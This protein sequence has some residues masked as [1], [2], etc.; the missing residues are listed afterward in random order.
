[1]ANQRTIIHGVPK[2]DLSYETA[3]LEAEGWI[4]DK[5]FSDVVGKAVN[6]RFSDGVNLSGTIIG[7]LPSNFNEGREI[8]LW[9]DN[10]ATVRPICVNHI[11][12][13]DTVITDQGMRD[14]LNDERGILAT[15]SQPLLKCVYGFLETEAL[16][17][18]FNGCRIG[19][20][21][22]A[23][24]AATQ[25]CCPVSKIFARLKQSDTGPHNSAVFEFL[26]T[27]WDEDISYCRMD[28]TVLTSLINS[29]NLPITRKSNL[30]LGLNGQ[31]IMCL[32][33][34]NVIIASFKD[35]SDM[36]DQLHIP[37]HIVSKISHEIAKG[38]DYSYFGIKFSLKCIPELQS[39]LLPTV[40]LKAIVTRNVSPLIYTTIKIKDIRT[41]NHVAL[42]LDVGAVSCLSL[43]GVKLLTFPNMFYAQ[44]VVPGLNLSLM[45]ACCY[46]FLAHHKGFKWS[47]CDEKEKIPDFRLA[48]LFQN[49]CLYSYFATGLSLVDTM[50]EGVEDVPES[51]IHQL[52]EDFRKLSDAPNY[53]QVSN[54]LQNE[55]WLV[56]QENEFMGLRVRRYFRSYG[57]SDATVVA[58]L[59]PDSNDG[60]PLWHLIH[61]DA[62]E[63]DVEYLQLMRS[64]Y[65]S[66]NVSPIFGSLSWRSSASYEINLSL[67]LPSAFETHSSLDI[68]SEDFLLFCE[69]LSA[70]IPVRFASSFPV[71]LKC[72]LLLAYLFPVCYIALLVVKFHRNVLLSLV[73]YPVENLHLYCGCIVFIGNLS[74]PKQC[75]G[76]CSSIADLADFGVFG[77]YW[78]LH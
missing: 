17:L 47:K 3:S 50:I 49:R 1:L 10:F 19:V 12:I 33:N 28:N 68:T 8:Y 61:D 38:I 14:S 62:D 24:D 65:N 18:S 5:E 77:R 58:Y 45:L 57:F 4:F 34:N 54:R 13:Q 6:L 67:H 44:S 22:N 7:A 55:G 30:V 75:D 52:R 56:G 32:T 41:S 23:Y 78:R 76:C 69:F 29:T 74:T 59:P 72:V 73:F 11:D 53:A 70:E 40:V 66:K 15:I 37:G 43:D 71:Q 21:C 60:I 9:K 48:P 36:M 64:I 31:K 27:S 39:F 46:G 16:Q 26:R 25:L 51:I 63:E 20:F 2:Q 42:A 35:M